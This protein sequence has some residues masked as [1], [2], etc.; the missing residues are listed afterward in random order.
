MLNGHRQSSHSSIVTTTVPTEATATPLTTTAQPNVTISTPPVAARPILTDSL[1][2]LRIRVPGQKIS[3]IQPAC[4]TG[5]TQEFGYYLHRENNQRKEAPATAPKL[6]RGLLPDNTSRDHHQHDG[7][8]LLRPPLDPWIC[9]T[10]SRG[11]SKVG[12][13]EDVQLL[14]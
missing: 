1:N 7:N 14:F 13:H 2:V 9:S 3:R 10:K 4:L 5:S 12:C 6:R 11:Y 8:A